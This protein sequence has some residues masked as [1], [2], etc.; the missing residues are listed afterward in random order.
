MAAYAVMREDEL[1]E[2]KIPKNMDLILHFLSKSKEIRPTS[3]AAYRLL[4]YLLRKHKAPVHPKRLTFTK[5]G[6]PY[7]RG[8]RVYISLSHSSGFVAAAISPYPVGIDIEGVRPVSD[9]AKLAARLFSPAEAEKMADPTA[10]DE[11]YIRL[12]TKKEAYLKAEDYLLFE[13][14]KQDMTCFENRFT[15]HT[16]EENGVKLLLTVY[17][18]PVRKNPPR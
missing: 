2:E 16:I 3:E 1:P 11:D 6:K 8:S 10:T 5:A 12:F 13:G 9:R 18:N 14:L 15:C 17:E 7:F 4:F